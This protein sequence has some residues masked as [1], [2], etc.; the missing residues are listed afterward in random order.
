[1]GGGGGGGGGEGAR[2][3]EDV[4]QPDAGPVRNG[5]NH[6]VRIACNQRIESRG[7]WRGPEDCAAEA[8]PPK[9]SLD[10]IHDVD[11]DKVRIITLHAGTRCGMVKNTSRKTIRCCY[12]ARHYVRRIAEVEARGKQGR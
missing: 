12:G 1:L 3:V 2:K 8:Q 6:M 5:G 10:V 7:T 9:I 11:G 4:P